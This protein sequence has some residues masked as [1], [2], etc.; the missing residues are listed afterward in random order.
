[1]H[2]CTTHFEFAVHNVQMDRKSRV[3]PASNKWGF[4]FMKLASSVATIKVTEAA[5]LEFDI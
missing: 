2:L 3:E 4:F 1:M 5:A